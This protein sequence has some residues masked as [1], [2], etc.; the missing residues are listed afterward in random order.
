MSLLYKLVIKQCDLNSN[1]SKRYAGG[2]RAKSIAKFIFI[3]TDQG[4]QT[5]LILQLKVYS[6][7]IS[8]KLFILHCI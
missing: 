6:D 3:S 5:D 4:E 1:G 7:D 2:V 8:L